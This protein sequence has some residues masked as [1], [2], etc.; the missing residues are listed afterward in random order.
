[1]EIDS[2]KFITAVSFAVASIVIVVVSYAVHVVVS[3]R[4]LIQAQQKLKALTANLA[5]AQERER[6]LIAEELHDR[7][8]ETLVVSRRAIEELK[9]RLASNQASRELDKLSQTIQTFMKGTRSLIFDLIPPALYDIGL[10]AAVESFATHCKS[11]YRINVRVE[12]SGPS[13]QIAPDIAVFL[14]NAVRELVLNAVKHANA[15]AVT[16]MLKRGRNKYNVVVEDNGVGFT[17]TQKSPTP[18]GLSGFGLFN[19]QVQAE[20][21]G[22][23]LDIDES[24]PSG[25]RVSVWVSLTGADHGD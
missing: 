8:G 23:Y 21:Y 20:H 9:T 10:E 14:Y 7:V 2:G 19:I 11:Q 13:K 25:A 6:K 1:M 18:I 17:A 22:G 15:D 3:N 16:I 5:R 12:E 4:R 24:P